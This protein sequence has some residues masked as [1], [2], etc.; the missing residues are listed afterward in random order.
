MLIYLY[1]HLKKRESKEKEA[2]TEIRMK[3]LFILNIQ[4][5]HTNTS[6]N[7]HTACCGQKYVD[8]LV[9]GQN[10]LPSN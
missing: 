6:I 8:N 1:I 4:N 3:H 10:V 7:M 9:L 5:I 2:R